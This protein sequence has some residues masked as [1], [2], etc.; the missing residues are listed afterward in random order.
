MPG[1]GQTDAEMLVILGA[2]WALLICA[3]QNVGDQALKTSY[4]RMP[5]H[6]RPKRPRV[7][8]VGRGSWAEDPGRAIS[9]GGECS[10]W[11]RSDRYRCGGRGRASLSRLG[12]LP[13]HGAR[14][15]ASRFY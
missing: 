13:S 7:T 4:R 9:S 3:D 1:D 5:Q 15:C 11:V 10:V 8:T 2:H 6:F 14:S 12:G